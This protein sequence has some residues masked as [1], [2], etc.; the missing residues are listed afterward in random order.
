MNNSA[1]NLM[2]LGGKLVVESTS[3]NRLQKEGLKAGID[4]LAEVMKSTGVTE[5]N[6]FSVIGFSIHGQAD[7]IFCILYLRFVLLHT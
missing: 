2:A 6:N 5:E 3:R 1:I 7:L 4:I